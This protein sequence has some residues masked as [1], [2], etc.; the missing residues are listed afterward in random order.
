[1]AEMRGLATKL[2]SS[3]FFSA[4][5]ALALV[6]SRNMGQ[7]SGLILDGNCSIRQKSAGSVQGLR[8]L[9]DGA[10]LLHS[11]RRLVVALLGSEKFGEPQHEGP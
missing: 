11:L 4:V 8:L 7:P 9:D 3:N 10:Y 1:V 2:L 5:E 6:P